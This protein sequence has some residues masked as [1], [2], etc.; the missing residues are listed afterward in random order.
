MKIRTIETQPGNNLETVQ[1]LIDALQT[2]KPDQRIGLATGGFIV[3]VSEH[4]I[5]IPSDP[6]QHVKAVLIHDKRTW[7][8]ATEEMLSEGDPTG[9]TCLMPPVEAA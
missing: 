6:P 8:E 7:R 3:A 2:F 9:L 4:D 5:T 1:D